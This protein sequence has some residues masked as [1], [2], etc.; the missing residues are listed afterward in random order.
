MT[1]GITDRIGID[2]PSLVT[3]VVPGMR[4]TF[5]YETAPFG[6]ARLV[7]LTAA[8]D[9]RV[10]DHGP[11]H[12]GV[13][14]MVGARHV[15]ARIDATGRIAVWLTD[16]ERHPIATGGGTVTAGSRTIALAPEGDALVG[17]DAAS[18]GD[19][20]GLTVTLADGLRAS[21]V[22]PLAAAD[23][24][25]A[26][27][28]QTACT[29]AAA[30]PR[31]TIAFDE[32]ITALAI[33]PDGTTLVVATVG[34][35]PSVWR[36]PEGTLVGGV[37]PAPPAALPIGEEARAG[38]VSNL[39]WRPDGG[40][41]AVVLEGR[42]LRHPMPARRPVRALPGPGGL[43]QSVAWWPDGSR[44]LVTTAGAAIVEA[45]DAASGAVVGRYHAAT[46]ALTALVEGTG[47]T[48]LVGSKA[49]TIAR[50]RADGVH[51]ATLAAGNAAVVSFAR[52]DDTI[53]ALTT[54]G[55]VRALDAERGRWS[56]ATPVGF[57][58]ARFAVGPDGL[59]AVPLPNGSVVLVDPIAGTT[60]RT[61]AGP[62]TPIRAVAWH[63]R[64]LVTG[65]ADG[66][67]AI[68]DVEP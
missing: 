62:A 66:R 50:F 53:V 47:E 39:A 37:E 60:V 31:C 40:E 35:D 36:L 63:G 27:T 14:A 32:P 54:E 59:V 26:G 38:V 25:V 52:V 3:D 61:L 22:L 15:E 16:R 46:D 57:T 30:G 45:I 10:A 18:G 68:W 29:P 67:V 44:V 5:V 23:L 1:A 41:I 56:K 17:R 12:G 19:R 8:D 55:I 34:A 11:R 7:R 13:V 6:G 2:D 64:T 43:V 33:S 51:V 20:I 9:T 4:V 48:V 28:A 49:G 58:P 24:G 65:A 42:V 21:F